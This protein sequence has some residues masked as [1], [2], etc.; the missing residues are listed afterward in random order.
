MAGERSEIPTPGGR[1]ENVVRLAATQNDDYITALTST[2][3][4]SPLP[5]FRFGDDGNQSS[6]REPEDGTSTAVLP[7][8]TSTSSEPS[9]L[10][11]DDEEE[12]DDYRNADHD[13]TIPDVPTDEDNNND[14]NATDRSFGTE[15]SRFV[16]RPVTP[17][18][19]RRTNSS[20]SSASVASPSPQQEEQ[21]T[22]TKLTNRLFHFFH[23]I[24][25]NPNSSLPRGRE[26]ERETRLERILDAAI[27][28]SL[29][30]CMVLG[31]LILLYLDHHRLDWIQNNNNNEK[32]S[33]NGITSLNLNLNLGSYYYYYNLLRGGRRNDSSK[34]GRGPEAGAGAFCEHSVAIVVV[35]SPLRSWRETYEE[36]G[37]AYVQR[38][39][40]QV[41]EDGGCVYPDWDGGQ[42]GE[43]KGERGDGLVRLRRVVYGYSD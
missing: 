30:L 42:E 37:L 38:F 17:I 35:S 28:F 29:L 27:A 6:S 24:L 23:S 40:G 25:K 32:S 11:L 39:S 33:G 9:F 18:Q 43:Q 22:R 34:V 8:R 36:A 3:P 7:P 16:S 19:R 14:D 13:T 26:R 4:T 10:L 12:D 31:V 41:G 15:S 20:S 2:T 5:P 1:T 21:R